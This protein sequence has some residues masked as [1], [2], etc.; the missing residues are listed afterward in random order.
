MFVLEHQTFGDSSS[1]ICR[2]LR[3]GKL[4][5]Q[6]IMQHASEIKENGKLVVVYIFVFIYYIF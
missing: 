3:A 1:E 2:Y 6:N 5:V 4:F